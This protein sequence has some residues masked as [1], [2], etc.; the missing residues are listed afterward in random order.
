[1]RALYEA[2]TRPRFGILGH[3]DA[4]AGV[5]DAHYGAWGRGD[6]GEI[7]SYQQFA[8]DAAEGDNAV[9]THGEQ[10]EPVYVGAVRE[11]EFW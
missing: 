2:R 9:K 7:E 11:E 3:L 8:V 4:D 5:P 1:M 10:G 6:G